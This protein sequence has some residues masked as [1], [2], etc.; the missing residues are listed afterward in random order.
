MQQQKCMYCF[1]LMKKVHSSNGS[2]F[3]CIVHESHISFSRGIKLPNFNLSK[4]IEKLS[5]YFCSQTIPNGQSYFVV[6]VIVS[7]HWN[8]YMKSSLWQDNPWNNQDKNTFALLKYYWIWAIHRVWIQ[9]QNQEVVSSYTISAL[10]PI[11]YNIVHR[12]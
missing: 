1:Y 5:P 2:N 11:K 12:V 8:K 4:A 3:S 10:N 9:G 6:F 7:L